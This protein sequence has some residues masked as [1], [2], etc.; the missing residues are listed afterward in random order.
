MTRG[1]R[2]S[3]VV[4]AVL[5]VTACGGRPVVN[6]QNESLK[7]PEPVSL[8]QVRVEIKAAAE[9]RGWNVEKLSSN[10]LEATL[11]YRNTLL[12][13][14]IDHTTETFSI[15]YK[16]SERLGYDGSK[17]HKLANRWIRNLRKMILMRTSKM[18]AW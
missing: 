12:V 6:Y 5:V 17:I 9:T 3:A 10:K 4:F 11:D 14:D 16:S 7:N 1:I 18:V 2:L 13:V 8:E 15:N